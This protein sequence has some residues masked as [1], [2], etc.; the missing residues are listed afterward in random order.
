MKPA[1]LHFAPGWV[2]MDGP[3]P[4]WLPSMAEQIEALNQPLPEPVKWAEINRDR[5]LERAMVVDYLRDNPRS[6]VRVIGPAVGICPASAAQHLRKLRLDG[7]AEFDRVN[8]ISV[9]WLTR[10]PR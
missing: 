7:L 6:P 9:W 2:S 3:F 8:D 10:F 1:H 4:A 5:A